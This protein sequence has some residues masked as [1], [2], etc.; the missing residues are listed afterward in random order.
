LAVGAS[1]GETIIALNCSA[2]IVADDII[3]LLKLCDA[4]RMP[5]ENIKSEK[6][7]V[8]LPS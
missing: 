4:D 5:K 2:V 6:V 1:L 7:T 3:A 8:V